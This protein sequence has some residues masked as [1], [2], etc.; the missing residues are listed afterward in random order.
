MLP[1]L[2]TDWQFTV[3]FAAAA[4]DLIDGWLGRCLGATSQFGQI[5]DPIADKVLVMAAVLCAV[6]A[7][8]LSWT[9]V[10]ALAARDLTVFVLSGLFLA[11][12]WRNW[13]KLKPRLTGK[14]ATGAQA[15]A[16][17]VLYWTQG[18]H[19]ILIAVAGGIS[20]LSAL[21]YIW[22]QGQCA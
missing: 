16:L 3:L 14:I 6:R 2:P 9:E 8:W 18:P 22:S 17:L 20:I 12:N 11:H 19:P 5:S 13:R 7:E 15:V 10:L 4:S 21:D 1:W